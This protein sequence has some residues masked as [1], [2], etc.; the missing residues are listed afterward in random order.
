MIFKPLFLPLKHHLPDIFSDI[1]K[2]INDLKEGLLVQL[3]HIAISN[4]HVR[5]ESSSALHDQIAL[6]KDRALLEVLL[7][8][9]ALYATLQEE[10]HFLRLRAFLAEYAI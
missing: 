7:L 2:L 10:E 1:R 9:N 8:V 3:Q 5:R 6:P 4:C